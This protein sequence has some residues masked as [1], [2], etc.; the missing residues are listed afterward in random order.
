[1]KPQYRKG[2]GLEDLRIA[3][4]NFSPK[5]GDVLTSV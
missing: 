4:K 5:E 3:Q 1:M 2:K